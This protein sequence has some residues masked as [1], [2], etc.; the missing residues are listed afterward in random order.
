MTMEATNDRRQFA[1][2]EAKW[3]VTALVERSEVGVELAN[4]SPQGV[5]IYSQKPL[6]S[7]KQMRL[8]ITA[9]DRRTL[10]AEGSVVWSAG[11]AVGEHELGYRAGI[12]F[13][14]MAEDDRRYLTRVITGVDRTGRR[15]Q[16]TQIQVTNVLVFLLLI[17][18]MGILYFNLNTK[19]KDISE[20]ALP[21][22]EAALQKVEERTA[23][24]A[25]LQEDIDIMASIRQA[26]SDARRDIGVIV[27][28]INSVLVPAVEG[29][30][31]KVYGQP[32]ALERITLA[33]AMQTGRAEEGTG[34]RREVQNMENQ[35]DLS[36]EPQPTSTEII[37]DKRLAFL[38]TSPPE[39]TPR[40]YRRLKLGNDLYGVAELTAL[41]GAAS[42][43]R[44]GEQTARANAKNRLLALI[45]SRITEILKEL[46]STTGKEL[47]SVLASL[48]KE[49]PERLG[50]KIAPVVTLSQVAQRGGREEIQV[51]LTVKK[52]DV[53]PL[54]EGEV[55][56]EVLTS[57]RFSP[58]ERS[59]AQ[60][61]FKSI[62][63]A[64]SKKPM[65]VLWKIQ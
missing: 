62:L 8:F 25:T 40:S 3:P 48:P 64:E 15:A 37:L 47:N 53:L 57:G 54:L 24:L 14:E 60:S 4:L 22:V 58:Q 49:I 21:R 34:S 46:A 39:T 45:E 61:K 30:Q 35:S 56:K 23:P 59:E 28:N 38:G 43:P 10:Q 2:I 11:E 41:E 51:L 13:T 44:E 31:R 12:R 27:Q 36:P 1:R 19:M 18:L 16:S 6:L 20:N 26:T 33:P 17:V 32:V 29:L 50:T 63:A 52:G 7:Q 5:L 9:P 55:E 42:S 65:D